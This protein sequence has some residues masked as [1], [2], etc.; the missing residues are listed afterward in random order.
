MMKTLMVEI[1]LPNNKY[2][3]ELA[4]QLNKI[5][6]LTMFSKTSVGDIDSEISCKKK[7]YCGGEEKNKIIS[8]FKYIKGMLSLSREIRRDYDVIHL[9]SFGYAGF[10]TKIC[11]RM[12][13]KDQ[14]LVYTVHNVLPHEKKSSDK[15]FCKRLYDKCDALIAHNEW[16]KTQLVSEFDIRENKIHVI[17]HGIYGNMVAN[18]KACVERTSF[19]MFG[20][21]RKYKGVDILLKAISLLPSAIREKCRFIIAGKQYPDKDPTDY[22]KMAEELGLDADIK[23]MLRRIEDEELPLLFENS[24]ACV[25]PY[26]EIYGSGSLLMAYTYQKPVI[27]SN[28]PAFI[29]ETQNGKTGLLFESEKPESLAEAIERFAGQNEQQRQTYSNH[30]AELVNEKYNWILSAEKTAEVYRKAIS[31]KGNKKRYDR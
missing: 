21:I 12:K 22:E 2:P 24:D 10:E 23:F 19:L 16:T 30:I 9:Q 25:F 8:A 3:L 4:R 31:L 5:V 1:I 20:L 29:E 18:N 7:L 17:A 14:A 28:V 26:R 15:K 27:T 11:M 6:D 13:R